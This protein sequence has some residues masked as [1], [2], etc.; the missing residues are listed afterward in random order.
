MNWTEIVAQLF[1]LIILPLLTIGGIYL[2][3]LIK[4]KF[5]QLKLEKNDD[6]YTKY[7]TML[8]NTITSCVLAT[9]QTYVDSLKQQGKFDVEAQKE[10]FRRTYN[11]VLTILT[12]DA[13]QYLTAV[14]GDL[15]TYITAKIEAEVNRTK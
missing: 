6:L 5:Q 1:N 11:N 8:E 2:I 7:L 10:A 4:A 12:E 3:T 13:K 9:T 14:F 15:E